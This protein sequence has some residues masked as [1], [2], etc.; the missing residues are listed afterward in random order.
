MYFHFFQANMG[1]Q[2]CLKLCVQCHLIFIP[3][4]RTL[5]SHNTANICH[6]PSLLLAMLVGDSRTS[7]WFSQFFSLLSNDFVQF[8]MCL[9]A[10]FISSFVRYLLKLC[11]FFDWID[12][13]FIKMQ[14]FTSPLPNTGFSLFKKYILTVYGLFIHFLN[15]VF[16]E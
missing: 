9:L 5:L 11:S 16:N 12:Y 14:F 1:Y 10:I 6:Y 4:L 7:C 13:F 15:D 3:T 2:N 8:F